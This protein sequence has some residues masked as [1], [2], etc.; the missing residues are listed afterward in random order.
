VHGYDNGAGRAP[1]L[2]AVAFGLS[3]AA[4]EW[5]LGRSNA[6]THRKSGHL[7]F[8]D[9]LHREKL[10]NCGPGKG[11]GSSGVASGFFFVFVPITAAFMTRGILGLRG[12]HLVNFLW[13][14]M[15][16]GLTRRHVSRRLGFPSG[17]G[18]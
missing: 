17:S 4:A 7:I 9:D 3:A 10:V 16:P 6:R 1:V 11:R 14:L 12:W 8:H 15:P 18:R 5:M 13:F 2:P